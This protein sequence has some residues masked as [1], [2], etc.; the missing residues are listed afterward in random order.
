[1]SGNWKLAIAFAAV[2]G[3][4]TCVALGFL[5]AAM[6]IAQPGSLQVLDRPPSEQDMPGGDYVSMEDARMEGARFLGTYSDSSYFAA[7][8][9]YDRNSFCL[10]AEPVMD[11]DEWRATC[12]RMIDGRDVLTSISDPEGRWAV[13]VPDQ[14]DHS[15]LEADGWV[16]VHQNLLVQP[17]MSPPAATRSAAT[18]RSAETVR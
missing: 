7:P 16:S 1:V 13:L 15:Q 6:F 10:I 5:L 8:S 12:N 11:N 18:M 14:F 17:R 3:V 2:V 4:G 9:N